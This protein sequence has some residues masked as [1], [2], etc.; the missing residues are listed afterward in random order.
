[1]FVAREALD[2]KTTLI[3]S[4]QTFHWQE[5]GGEYRAFVGGRLLRVRK[6]AGGWEITS[7]R[8]TGLEPG[9]EA[10]LRGYFDLDRDYAAI[11][12]RLGAYPRAAE[13]MRL[14][15]GLRVLRQSPWEA[16]LMFLCSQNN[17]AAR[18][19]AMVQR[20]CEDWGPSVWCEGERVWGLPGPETLAA[21]PEEELRR[22]K[23][24][25]RARYIVRSARAVAEGFPLE[26]AA[27]LPY[28]EAKA[29]LTALPG[30]GGK[31]ADCVLLFGCG[32]TE[33]FPVDVW[34][35][36]LMEKWFD[37][38]DK[39]RGETSRRAMEMFGPEAGIVQQYLF[40]CAR[41]GLIGV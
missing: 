22:R 27:R 15:P 40:H 32:H 36:R 11:A 35:E 1:M 24:G 29:L 25:Y 2:A 31:V 4:A 18:I 23:F 20:L 37:I 8:A 17:H 5:R 41:T 26:D 7:V 13:A 30:V 28:G 3:D 9:D 33:A 12:A 19:R 39:T 14:L 21:V 38:K 10:F 16:L 6:A 34:V